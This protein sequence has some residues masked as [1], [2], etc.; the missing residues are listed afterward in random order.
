[1]QG[2]EG[3]GRDASSRKVR[4]SILQQNRRD[5]HPAGD[6]QG[7]LYGPTPSSGNFEEKIGGGTRKSR[8]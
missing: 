1:M 2:K 8:E 4:Q 7:L 6:R 3:K 5:R